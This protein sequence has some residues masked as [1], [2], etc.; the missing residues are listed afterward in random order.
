MKPSP[1]NSFLPVKNVIY[2]NGSY[3]SIILYLIDI[4][5]MRSPTSRRTLSNTCQEISSTFLLTCIIHW[6]THCV[7]E[8]CLCFFTDMSFVFPILNTAS[9]PL[10]L[11]LKRREFQILDEEKKTDRYMGLA[12]RKKKPQD[13]K[14]KACQ[15]IIC[16]LPLC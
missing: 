12:T 9:I 3:L 13:L 15:V 7:Q 5:Q 2:G 4:L 1:C 10:F 14:L 11:K 8:K 16:S 6:D